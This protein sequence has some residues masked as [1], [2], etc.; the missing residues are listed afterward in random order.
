MQPGTHGSTFGSNPMACAVAN[1][2]LK[3]INDLGFLDE[4]HR[5]EKL[6]TE[7]LEGL[8]KE[9]RYFLELGQRAYG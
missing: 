2:V 4:V 7:L 9:K 1:E 5:K 6:F 3:I 8:N